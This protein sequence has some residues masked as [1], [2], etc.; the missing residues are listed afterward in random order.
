MKNDAYRN[1][2]TYQ[3]EASTYRHHLQSYDAG[4]DAGADALC[5]HPP[6]ALGLGPL[7]AAQRLYAL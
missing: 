2:D 3:H 4:A 7:D 6:D 1:R 5:S